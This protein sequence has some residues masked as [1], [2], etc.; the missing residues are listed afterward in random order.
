MRGVGNESE[1]ERQVEMVGRE[2]VSCQTFDL[3]D[4]I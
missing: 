1:I 2:V 4:L 3:L